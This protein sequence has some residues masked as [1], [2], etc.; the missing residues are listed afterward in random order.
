[1]NLQP[2]TQETLCFQNAAGK[3]FYQPAGYVRL[4][5]GADR[6]PLE[7]IQ[8]YYGQVLSLLKSTGTR[9]I[10]S[11]HGQRPPLSG[12]AQEWLTNTWIPLAI[13]QAR[14]RYCAIVEGSDPLHR[15]STQSVVSA[16]PSGLIFQ[17]F[18]NSQD[19][20]AWLLAAALSR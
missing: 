20:E 15:L 2:R 12:A 4:A 6:V 16:S 11:E 19:A 9:K 3:L 5:W 1:M 17:R 13:G 18:N 10:M 7:V 14:V 8:A